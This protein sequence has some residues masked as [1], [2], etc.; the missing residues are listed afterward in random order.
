M[1]KSERDE[2]ISKLVR[3]PFCTFR[4][5]HRPGSTFTV[6]GA[7][8]Y[9]VFRNDQRPCDGRCVTGSL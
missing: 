2:V 5:R 8:L 9:D 6:L 3:L 7:D 1:P 4:A